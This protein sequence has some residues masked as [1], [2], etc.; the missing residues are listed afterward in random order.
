MTI[1]LCVLLVRRGG[2][3]SA[4]ADDIVA[5]ISAICSLQQM[6]QWNTGTPALYI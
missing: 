4:A 3:P 5:A 1:L 6:E 2:A